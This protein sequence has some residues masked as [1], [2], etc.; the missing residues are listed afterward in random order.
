MKLNLGWGALRALR[1][2]GTEAAGGL[3]CPDD[4]EWIASV[5]EVT[6]YARDLAVGL[7][8]A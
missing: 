1:A 3:P 4:A 7:M 8:D 2:L 5:H 6:M